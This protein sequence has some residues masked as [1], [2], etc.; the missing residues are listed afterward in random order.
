MSWSPFRCLDYLT[1]QYLKVSTVWWR[2]IASN[3]IGQC[4]HS[5]YTRTRGISGSR[6][7]SIPLD[8]SRREVAHVFVVIALSSRIQQLLLTGTFYF[9]LHFKVVHCKKVLYK[10]AQVIR[11]IWNNCQWTTDSWQLFHLDQVT[12]LQSDFY[13]VCK[14]WQ[15]DTFLTFSRPPPDW[16][17]LAGPAFDKI[18]SLYSPVGQ[19]LS[20][21]EI[22]QFGVWASKS[23]YLQFW[24][25]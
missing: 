9:L 11:V 14:F 13:F 21:Y 1:R 23:I 10:F 6:G 17:T 4:S 20:F 22:M 18:E 15:T 24:P 16:M 7:S 25:P 8:I 2:I 12:E 5:C 19:E 3:F